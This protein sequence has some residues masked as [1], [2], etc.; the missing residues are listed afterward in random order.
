LRENRA[1]GALSLLVAG[2]SL[3][4]LSNLAFPAKDMVVGVKE[5][6]AIAVAPEMLRTYTAGSDQAID[7]SATVSLVN[8]ESGLS[9]NQYKFTS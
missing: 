3:L 4:A 8:A 1:L 2:V 5:A 7:V 9:E 6:R